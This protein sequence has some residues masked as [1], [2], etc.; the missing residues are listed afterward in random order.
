MTKD[1]LAALLR[2]RTPLLS[3]LQA[4]DVRQLQDHSYHVCAHAKSLFVK[5]FA[6]TDRRGAREIECYQAVLS[7]SGPAVPELLDSFATD[8]FIVGIWDW[9]DGPDLRNENRAR[10]AE[11]FAALGRFHAGYRQDG[12]TESPITSRHYSSIPEQLADE[13]RLLGFL[14]STVDLA[15]CMELLGVLKLGHLSLNHGDLHPGNVIWAH[16]TAYIVDWGYAHQG[17][18]FT[19]LAYLWDRRVLARCPRDWWVIEGDEA[20]DCAEAYLDAAGYA[21]LHVLTVLHAVMLWAQI[22]AY[23][24]ALRNG[25]ADDAQLC[26]QRIKW[27]LGTGG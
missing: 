13:V 21:H 26:R 8:E 20:I 10:L 17:V 24:N 25:M 3:T 1:D 18:G 4:R 9:L 2:R 15:R 5:W 14:D 23:S 16:G 27:M 22:W 6:K 11:A 19:D 12:Q 7:G